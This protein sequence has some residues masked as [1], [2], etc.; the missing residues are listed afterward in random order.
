MKV[1]VLPKNPLSFKSYKSSL[2]LSL[3][4]LETIPGRDGSSIEH[5]RSST[6][7]DSTR[8]ESNGDFLFENSSRAEVI[9]RSKIS[10]SSRADPL[11]RSMFDSKCSKCSKKSHIHRFICKSWRYKRILN[12]NTRSLHAPPLHLIFDQR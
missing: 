2:S 9:A 7:L 5:A 10:S 8:I 1:I 11:A 6:R 3:N 12:N 4:I